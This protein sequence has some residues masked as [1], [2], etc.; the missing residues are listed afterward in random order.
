M[1]HRNIHREQEQ[2]AIYENLRKL[3]K[4]EL[5]QIC[6]FRDARQVMIAEIILRKVG[7]PNYQKG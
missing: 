7:D 3:S 2:T 5:A 1:H 6:G 4:D